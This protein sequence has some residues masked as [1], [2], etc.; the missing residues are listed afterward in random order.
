M[1]DNLIY[2][3]YSATTPIR[4]EVLEAMMPWLKYNFGNPSA[5]YSIGKKAKEAIENARKQIANVINAEPD[6]IY[7][8][9]GGTESDNWV[10]KG[11]SSCYSDRPI[12]TSE[13]E[14]DAIL[15]SICEVENESYLLPVDYDGNIIINYDTLK[16][17]NPS[18]VSI[19]SANN[20]IG[21]IEPFWEIGKFCRENGILFHTDA[22][23]AFGKIPIDVKKNNIDLLSI[24]GHK[25][26]A[27]KGVGALYIRNGIE[28]PSFING[29]NQ[30]YG[31]RAGTENVASIVGFGKAAELANEE[32]E[33]E[34]NR[35]TKMADMLI[36]YV[37]DEIKGSHLTG[38]R[39]RISGHC[40]FI[41][42][43]VEGEALQLLM[44]MDGICVSTGSACASGSGEPSHVLTA[45]GYKRED[46]N[47]MLRITFGYGNDMK[48]VVTIFNSLDRNIDRLR[49]IHG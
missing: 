13:I 14:H 32:M 15:K 12:V 7:F 38:S 17:L 22:V 9:S 33:E 36:G 29:G 4:E 44:D 25:I 26:G 31:F 5:Q 40:S 43:G 28:L 23:Q 39:L 1:D 19:M 2:A 46:T 30:E 24:S 49:K 20:E 47:S 42:D 48:D 27:P 21:T 41:F 8:T 11:I 37:L 16:H 35:L 34:S 10:I 3:D 45:C 18:L 6:E